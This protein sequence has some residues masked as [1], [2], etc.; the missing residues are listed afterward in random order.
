MKCIIMFML[1]F[2]V[3][4]SIWGQGLEPPFIEVRGMAAIE[5]VI[6]SYTFDIVITED[7]VYT[8]EKRSLTQVKKEF[9]DKARAAGFDSSRF[10]EDKLVYALTQYTSAGGSLYSFETTTPAEVITLNNLT[11]DKNGNISV[12]AR[13]VTYLPVKDFS[14]ILSEAFA[15]GKAR[16][17]KM[18]VAA[19]K[20]LGPLQ[21][22]TDY[23]I[24]NEETE[25]TTYYQPKEARYYYLSLK[26]LI[27]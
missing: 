3:I 14:R 1:S 18:A 21:S 15:D 7:Q 25:D 23:S 13:R 2:T 12:T 5:R 11:N 27:E 20:K 8:E 6:K 4:C 17:E 9:F 26:Y 22:V 24:S 16:A 19:G 10:K